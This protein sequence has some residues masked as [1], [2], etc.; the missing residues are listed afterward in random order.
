ML[1]NVIQMET[2]TGYFCDTLSAKEPDINTIFEVAQISHIRTGYAPSFLPETEAGANELPK[3]SRWG[4]HIQPDCCFRCRVRNQDNQTQKMINQFNYKIA[5]FSLTLLT[6]SLSLTAQYSDSLITHHSKKERIFL[7]RLA[8]PATLIGLG[9][10]GNTNNSFINH[11]EIKEERN[12]YFPGF[13]NKVD[14]YLQFTPLPLVFAMDAFGLKGKHN[15]Q[16]QALLLGSAQ[17]VMVGLLAPIKKYTHILRPD[18][19]AF[20]SFPSGH[21]AQAFLAATFFNKEYGKN[22]PWISVGMY[23]IAGGIGL[24][25]ILNNK[26]WISDVLAGAGFGI[27]PVE[28]AYLFYKYRKKR[29]RGLPSSVIPYYQKGKLVCT[30]I[31][32]M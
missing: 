11:N 9:I 30:A 22:Y 23:T 13:S 29:V 31:F 3:P 6:L 19:S 7:K 17:I 20:N 2:D 27:L 16:Q 1:N 21:T 12:E 18:S 8:I 25:R 14:N 4:Y 10:Y 5:V 28:L 24:F 26:H 15:W 32:K